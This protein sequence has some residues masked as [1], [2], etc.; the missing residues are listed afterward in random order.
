[1][2]A[3]GLQAAICTPKGF[4]VSAAELAAIGRATAAA[5]TVATLSATRV[6]FNML[7]ASNH[8]QFFAA[9]REEKLSD[10]RAAP[11]QP[12]CR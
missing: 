6:F 11:K 12:R 9:P 7:K 10:R 1:L 3:Q 8:V 2:A 4:A 5:E